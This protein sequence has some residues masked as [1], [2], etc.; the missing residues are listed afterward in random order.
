MPEEAM[1]HAD[2]VC[3][4][5]AEPKMPR[6]IED[7]EARRLQPIYAGEP[8]P[9]TDL[10]IPRRDLIRKEDYAPIDMVQATRGC[11]QRCSFCSVT[12]FHHNRFRTR[13]VNE[14]IDELKDLGR[15][16]L[17]LDDAITANRDYALELFSAMAP[18]EKSWFSQCNV[19]IAGDEELLALAARSGCRGLFIGF[20][21][22][23]QEGLR[24]WKKRANLG[25]DYVDAVR[26]L[27]REG[28]AVQAAF[29]FGGDDDGPDVFARTLD[30]LLEANIECLQAT[31]LTPFPGTPLFEEMDQ[32]GRILDK[33]W[34]HYDFGHVVFEPAGMSRET[35]DRG[36]AWVQKEFYARRRIARRTWKALRYLE[37]DTIV[38]GVLP[39]N[40]GYRS[41]MTTVGTFDRAEGFGKVAGS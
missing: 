11:H 1:Q 5:D 28:I 30:F 38:R 10:P 27:H 12:A 9:L 20:E 17:F 36:V 40:L 14:V 7:L 29:V 31:R 3:V 19:G 34:S 6:I 33:D 22:L 18:L 26:R 24:S 35:L 4:G 41:K 16:I 13:P 23:S 8:A 37:P 21:S 39:I 25:R 32:Q 2:A 15:Y